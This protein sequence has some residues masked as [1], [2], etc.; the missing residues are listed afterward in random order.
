MARNIKNK[1]GADIIQA[2][3]IIAIFG[4]I[5]VVAGGALRSAV[6]DKNAD[7]V[8]AID[9]SFTSVDWGN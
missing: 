3:I 7:V 1:K 4:A 8:N 9:T 5:A 2:L 6:L